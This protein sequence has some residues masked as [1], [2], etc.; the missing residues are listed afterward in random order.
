MTRA[1]I[2]SLNPSP[3]H[4]KWHLN[5]GHNGSMRLETEAGSL[6]M[7]C[8]H[9]K[10]HDSSAVLRCSIDLHLH[11]KQGGPGRREQATSSS[12]ASAGYGIVLFKWLSRP[13]R[14]LDRLGTWLAKEEERGE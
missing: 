5:R 3:H 2:S 11:L 10:T 6:I 12:S 4:H 1:L 8:Q 9:Y 13:V 7:I 14:Y